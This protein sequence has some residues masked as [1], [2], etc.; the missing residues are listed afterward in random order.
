MRSARLVYRELPVFVRTLPRDHYLRDLRA[1]FAK[2]AAAR[3]VP[4]A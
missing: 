2:A 1:K 3:R 4:A